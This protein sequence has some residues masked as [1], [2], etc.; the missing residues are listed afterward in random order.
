[1]MCDIL[2]GKF[3]CGFFEEN[4]MKNIIIE[5]KLYVFFGLLLFGWINLKVLE[6]K[7]RF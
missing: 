5:N 4:L 6:M 7:E 1:M 2:Y 3:I